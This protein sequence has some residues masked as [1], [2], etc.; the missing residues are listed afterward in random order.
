MNKMNPK[1]IEQLKRA[2]VKRRE[3]HRTMTGR[4]LSQESAAAEMDI[5]QQTYIKAE[6]YGVFSRQTLEKVRKWLKSK[7]PKE[8]ILVEQD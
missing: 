1:E 4:I 6:L 8:K 5:H 7:P 3:L 2:M